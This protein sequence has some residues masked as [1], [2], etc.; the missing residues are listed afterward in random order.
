MKED[1][2]WPA[3][4]F[5]RLSWAA[6]YD[7]RASRNK[8]LGARGTYL[9]AIPAF[10][11][12]RAISISNELTAELEDAATTLAKFDFEVGTFTAPFATILLRTES[13]SSSE[14]ENLTVS[15]K[16]L[17]LAELNSSTAQNAKIVV[18]NV[19]AM[20]AALDLSDQL[21]G[22]SIIEMHRALL[23]RTN[24]EICG[25]WRNRA[26]WV[27]GYSPHSAKYVAPA[28]S[29]VSD[30]M[31]DLEKFMVRADLP[32]LAQVAIAHAQFESIHPFEDGNGRTGRALVQSMLR[33]TGLT[34]NTTVPVSAGLLHD[35]EGYFAA[36]DAYRLGDIEPIIRAFSEASFRA[37]DNGKKLVADLQAISS[38]WASRI[39]ARSDSSLAKLLVLLIEQPA[40][41]QPLLQQRLGVTPQAIFA[42]IERLVDAGVLHPLND[43]RRNRVWVSQEV[44]AALDAFAARSRRK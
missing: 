43:Y 7:P 26:V 37:V 13:A 39:K 35:T 23:E 27:G 41:T 8:N 34:T 1:R 18:D 6:D 44:L 9:A 40:I 33:H 29:R 31:A 38:G 10:I 3:V 42:A 16:Q 11:A 32:I 36:L 17:A 19:D 28:E 22:N 4:Q 15:A 21:T 30:L 5:E 25:A 24:P 2:A 14:V 12:H 20:R